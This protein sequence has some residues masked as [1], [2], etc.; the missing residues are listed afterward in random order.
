MQE[1]RAKI[2]LFKLPFAKDTEMPKSDSKNSTDS[3]EKLRP[4][5][6]IR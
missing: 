3:N 2:A 4:D 6:T 1:R 5:T